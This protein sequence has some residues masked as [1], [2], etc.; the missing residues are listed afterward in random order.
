[1]PAVLQV[2]YP[3]N[4]Y[5]HQTGGAEFYA[6]PLNSTSTAPY[7]TMLLTYDVAFSTY[8]NWVKGGKLPGLRGGPDR[9]GCSG[10]SEP[11]GSDCFSVRLMW[12]PEGAGE[13]YAYMP[14]PSGF[15]SQS[16]IICNSDYGISIQRGAFNFSS[17]SWQT[18][19][20][21]VQLND[22]PSASNGLVELYVNN[23]LAISQPGLVFRTTDNITSVGGLYFSTFFGGSDTTYETP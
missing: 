14:T 9:L 17:G 5:S 12:R 11:D 6:L 19:S 18:I 15:C 22:P 21:L 16:G 23:Q 7:T 10:G 4:S 20:L 2:T 1:T 8:F 13:V 3:A